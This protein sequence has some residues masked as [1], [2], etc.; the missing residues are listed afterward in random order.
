M[1]FS[2]TPEEAAFRAE[3]RAFLDAHMP[4]KAKGA[5]V[6]RAMTPEDVAASKAWQRL[7]AEN[8]FAGILWPK[9]YGGREGT[10]MQQI[11]F[12]QEEDRYAVPTT[13]FNQGVGMAMP[14]VM[15]F[16]TPDQLA[17]YPRPALFGDEVWCQLFSEPA[18]GSDLAGLRTRA[19]RDGD[20]WVINGQ[21]IWTSYAHF[22]DFGMLVVRTDPGVAKH[23]GLTFFVVD[24]TTP[25]IEIRPIKQISGSSNF[26][27][28]FFTDVRIPDSQRLGAVGEGWK[29]ALTMLANERFTVGKAE[30]PDFDDVLALA[31]QVDLDGT[32]AVDDSAVRERLAGWYIRTAGLKYTRLRSQTALS[33]GKAPGPENSILKLVSANKL[34]EIATFGIDLMDMAGAIT[35]PEIAAMRGLFQQALLYAPSKRIAGGTDEI[36]R[37]IIAERVLGLPADIR[38]DKGLAFNQIPTGAR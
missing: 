36:L 10:P 22:A 17:R 28:V 2:D 4:L 19:V 3:A 33:R 12:G 25:G 29:V 8:G 9:A 1:D 32:R 27:E 13:V 34:Q 6:S 31:Q 20:D 18:A 23:A 38:A 24:M 5:H 14:T 15:S 37:N 16:G 26:S 35:D 11:I 7:K 30:G 21:K